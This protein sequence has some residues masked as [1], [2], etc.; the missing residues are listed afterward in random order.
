MICV[1]NLA[2]CAS[3]AVSLNH[4]QLFVYHFTKGGPDS[5]LICCCAGTYTLDVAVLK[6]VLRIS[7][8]SK[9]IS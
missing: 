8:R 9:S 1:D 2:L 4:S 3:L 6:L 5:D 7:P